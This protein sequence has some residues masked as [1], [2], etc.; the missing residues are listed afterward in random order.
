[1]KAVAMLT[2]LLSGLRRS[3]SRDVVFEYDC[4]VPR[5]DLIPAMT[6]AGVDPDELLAALSSLKDAGAHLAESGVVLDGGDAGPSNWF[7]CTTTS[8]EPITVDGHTSMI[9]ALDAL[10]GTLL[11]AS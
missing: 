5:P 2:K 10:A 6:P 9:A 8:G 1:M 4:R 3:V 7:A 11:A